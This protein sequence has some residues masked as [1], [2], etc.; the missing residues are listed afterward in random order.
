M[1]AYADDLCI[2]RCIAG[3]RGVDRVHNI[4]Q[5]RELAGSFSNSKIYRIRTG[6]LHKRHFP[7][8]K[9][10]QGIAGYEDRR[11]R[12]KY[13]YVEISALQ[14]N[15][16]APDEHRHLRRSRFLDNESRQSL[17]PLCVYLVS[18]NIHQ[19]MQPAA[20]RSGSY[21]RGNQLG[22]VPRRANPVPRNTLLS[23]SN[24]QWLNYFVKHKVLPPS[25]KTSLL[26][27]SCGHQTHTTRNMIQS[28]SHRKKIATTKF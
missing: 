20:A 1:D 23:I 13:L 5:T 15:L 19:S 10:Q 16:G 6:R 25:D 7:L 24:Q 27:V 28:E 11:W 3:H 8:I 2:F 22:G 18:S 12:R 4:R 9:S 14:K 26:R 17:E 21:E